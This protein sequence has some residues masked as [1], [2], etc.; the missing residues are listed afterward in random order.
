MNKVDRYGGAALY[1]ACQEG[2]TAIVTILID[3]GANVNSAD[4]DRRTPLWIASCN[5]HTEVV[6]TRS[7]R[8]PR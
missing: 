5:N 2:H 7:A 3:A 1:I 6:T 4:E 8:R